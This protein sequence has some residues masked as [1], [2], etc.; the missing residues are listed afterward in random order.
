MKR[1]YQDVFL[2]YGVHF[3]NIAMIILGCIGLMKNYYHSLYFPSATIMSII[4]LIFSGIG[5]YGYYLKYDMMPVKLCLKIFAVLS[6]AIL[7]LSQNEFRY[8]ITN[9]K[10]VIVNDY[11][12]NI[13][14]L[15][16]DW[17][18]VR[19]IFYQ[20][21]TLWLGLPLI[22][23]IVSSLCSRR[24]SFLKTLI[25]ITLFLF[26]LLIK[27]SLSS[28]ES[29][30]FI[31]FM[32]YQFLAAVILKNQ[33]QQY[34]LKVIMVCILCIIT[35]VAS[36]YMESNPMFQQ[37]STSFLARFLDFS[38]EGQ[39]NPLG[40]VT[41]TGMSSDVDGTLPTGNIRL[42]KN[43]ALTVQAEIPFSSYL[44]AY[45]LANYQDN[46]WHEAQEDYQD[47]Q[48]LTTY[49][50][51]LRL[52]NSVSLETVKIT[53]E[54]HYD[55]Q[56]IPYYFNGYVDSD[57]SYS[58]VYDSYVEN[59]NRDMLVIYDYEENAQ[60]SDQNSYIIPGGYDEEY[61]E[62]VYKN[63]MDVPEELYDKLKDLLVEYGIYSSRLSV[64]ETI[65]QIQH[66]LAT[67]AQYDLNA[68]TLPADQDFVEY[69]LFEN[70][71]GSCTHFAT[72]GALLLRQ[73]G[74][75]TRFVR[76]YIMKASDFHEGKANIP[77][78]R[79]HAWIEVYKDG[80]GWIP[81]EMTPSGNME[82]MSDT[83]DETANQS[84]SDTDRENT[85][86][87][88]TQSD[89]TPDTT[90]DPLAVEETAT[91]YQY[92]DILIGIAGIA[93]L[94]VIY[95]Y[96]TTHWLKIK[97]RHMT[98]RQKLLIYYQVI[99]K[100]S[101]NHHIDEGRLKDLAY[102]AKYSLHEITDGEWEEFYNCYRQ[103][104]DHYDQTLKWCQKWVFRY[105]KGYK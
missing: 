95:R 33:Q 78:Y 59:T 92:A 28:R 36:V 32:G 31:I 86:D 15:I 6:V 16:P 9:L 46:E 64:D 54:H 39:S 57:V 77:Q 4:L 53:S 41:Q 20:L 44:R 51:F 23:L 81:Y 97:T 24:F 62:Y 100:L 2:K 40:I 3:L 5:F 35:S 79:S 26:P 42:N 72:A 37:K 63:Y 89:S 43:T 68:G 88:T 101:P 91:S 94:L 47:S 82:T 22:Y 11:F 48:S 70:K 7:I 10:E 55:F 85:P 60:S 8:F 29:Y 56:F 83:L 98:N 25:L 99:W 74:I 93:V 66:L 18:P 49:S 65:Q 38:M 45:S 67:Q 75:P 34:V 87:T 61:E 1:T 76:G 21:I 52:N 19:S 104:L 73:K 30:C 50:D 69:F 27:H 13:S 71:K 96:L 14:E 102:K 103:W 17:M 80:L 105:I 90:E 12:L 58:L 84:Q